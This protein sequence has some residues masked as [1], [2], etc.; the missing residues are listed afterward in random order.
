MKRTYRRQRS[1][2]KHSIPISTLSTI[3]KDREKRQKDCEDSKFLPIT[4]KIK[5]CSNEELEDAVFLWFRKPGRVSSKSE[6]LDK[7]REFDCQ[8]GRVGNGR[9]STIEVGKMEEKQI[10]VRPAN[11]MVSP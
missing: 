2:K 9:K 8:V 5:L 7:S 6:K 1:V 3:L 11:N 10:I 4:K